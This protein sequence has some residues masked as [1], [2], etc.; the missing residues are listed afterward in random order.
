MIRQPKEQVDPEMVAIRALAFIAED[1]ERLD[2]FL[3]L[4]GS[5]PETLR[6]G[7]GTP[8]FLSGVLQHVVGWEPLLLDFAASAGMTPADVASAA[9]RLADGI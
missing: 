2:R 4:T 3:S 7:A 6:S 9:D 1:P 5:R 8:G